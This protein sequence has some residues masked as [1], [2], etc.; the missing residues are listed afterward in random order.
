MTRPA[1]VVLA[2]GHGTRLRPLT[3][4]RPKALCPVGGVPLLDRALARLAPYTGAGPAHL[5]VNAHALADQV[6]RHVGDRAHVSVE[7]PEALGTAGAL[8]RLRDWVGGRDVLVTN[9]DAL[10]VG[11][12]DELLE[13]W[14]GERC[15]LLVVPAEGTGDFDGHRYVGACLLPGRLVG[16]LAAEPSGL[17]EVLWRREHEAGRLELVTFTG[18]AIDCGT[19]TDYLRANLTVSGGASVVGR[20]AVVEGTVERCVVWDGAYVGPGEHLV[21]VVRAGTREEPVTVPAPQ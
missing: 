20:G 6:V 8:G 10:L 7:Q 12:L 4:L 9:A 1:G 13:G 21:E 19:P 11:P 17:Y 2:A 14:D 3:T 16:G 15:R 18:T 5:A